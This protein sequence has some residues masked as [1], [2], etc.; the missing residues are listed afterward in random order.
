MAIAASSL[1]FP[2]PLYIARLYAAVFVSTLLKY[3]E[4]SA[5]L[6]QRGTQ[7][8]CPPTRHARKLLCHT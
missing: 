3:F 7:G 8:K 4:E 1:L 6:N 5:T 2:G